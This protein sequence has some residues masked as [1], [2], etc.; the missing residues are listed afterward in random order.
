MTTW[1]SLGARRDLVAVWGDSAVVYNT[2]S[3]E[4]HV[5]N[6]LAAAALLAL[7]ERPMTA[8]VLA[9]DLV[10]DLPPGSDAAWDREVEAAL[11]GM[12]ALGLVEATDRCG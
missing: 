2:L 4:T 10:R 11:S 9:Q 1:T 12:E 8:P 3:G 6:A 5:L 7:L